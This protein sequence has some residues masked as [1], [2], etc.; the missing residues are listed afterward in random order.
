MTQGESRQTQDLVV[1]RCYC[2]SDV[3]RDAGLKDIG[4]STND[5]ENG[6]YCVRGDFDGNGVT[7]YAFPGKGFGWEH[8]IDAKIVF[9]KKD[10]ILRTASIEKVGS[11][12]V[13]EGRLKEVPENR[14][15]LI[16]REPPPPPNF[17]AGGGA[18]IYCFDGKRFITQHGAGD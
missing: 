15:C 1:P 13:W 17:L 9:F 2:S 6:V 10:G 5:L 18:T 12:H 7:D 4:W 8:R 3:V 14:D 16:Q 11:L